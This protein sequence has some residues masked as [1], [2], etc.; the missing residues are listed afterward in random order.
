[1]GKKYVKKLDSGLN[2]ILMYCVVSAVWL[3]RAD[4][5][6]AGHDLECCDVGIRSTILVLNWTQGT[7]QNANIYSPLHIWEHIS[8][9][10]PWLQKVERAAAPWK[11]WQLFMSSKQPHVSNFSSHAAHFTHSSRMF[12][13]LPGQ[14]NESS[15]A[16]CVSPALC[17]VWRSF[18]KTISSCAIHSLPSHQ[19]FCSPIETLAS[20]S[21]YLCLHGLTI[22]RASL[23]FHFLSDSGNPDQGL[24]LWP[25]L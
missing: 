13:F 22:K 2:S 23:C 19:F 25:W 6:A 9:W 14:E 4:D 12:A 20:P 7:L 24:E 21:E 1:M 15:A 3:C 10:Q 11:P 8:T 18:Y 16:L 5:V 17:G